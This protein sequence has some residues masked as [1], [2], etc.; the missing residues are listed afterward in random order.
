MKNAIAGSALAI[1]LLLV[2]SLAQ[3]GSQPI[4]IGYAH[5]TLQEKKALKEVTLNYRY[6]LNNAWGILSS[7]SFAEGDGKESEEDHKVEFKCYSPVIGP[8]YRINE[9][10]SP[11]GQADIG[12]VANTWYG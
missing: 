8:V 9:Y 5:I 7:F 2:C 1:S 12:K 10:I 6:A 4:S 11:Y 3:A